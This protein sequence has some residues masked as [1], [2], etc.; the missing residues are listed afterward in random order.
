MVFDDSELVDHQPIVVRRIL[1]INQPHFV[2]DGSPVGVLVLHIDTI[3]KQSMGRLVVLDQAQLASRS[4]GSRPE[5]GV[6]IPR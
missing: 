1:E 5:Q 6:Q 3:D 4:S 2:M